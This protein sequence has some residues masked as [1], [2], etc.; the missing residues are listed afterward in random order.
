MKYLPPVLFFAA[1]FLF[2]CWHYNDFGVSTDEAMNNQNARASAKFVL[3]RLMPSWAG[4]YEQH[5]E[6]YRETPE[7]RLYRDK[8]YGVAF[9]LPVF[10]L[11]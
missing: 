3:K 6:T 10:A 5:S 11:Q 4:W 2:G 7:L 8:F 1:Y 9:D